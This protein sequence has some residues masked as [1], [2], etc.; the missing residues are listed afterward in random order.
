MMRTVSSASIRKRPR[1][2]L[3]AR[4]SASISPMR[5]S[6][7]GSRTMPPKAMGID[8]MTGSLESGKMADIVLWNGDPLSVYSRPEKVWIDGVAD[9]RFA[10]SQTSPGQRF[11][12]GAARRRGCEMTARKTAKKLSAAGRVRPR[13]RSCRGVHRLSGAGAECRR[14]QRHRGDRR[15]QRSDRERCRYRR[16]GQGHLCRPGDRCRFFSDRHGYRCSGVNG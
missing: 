1:R 7:P 16:T 12:T 13:L 8:A 14:H 9:V 2:R 4:A 3:R 11:R 15:W 6:F 5:R 10:G